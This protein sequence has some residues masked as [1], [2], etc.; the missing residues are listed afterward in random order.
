M[1][2]SAF[3][4]TLSRAAPT[5]EISSSEDMLNTILAGPAGPTTVGSTTSKAGQLAFLPDAPSR[6]ADDPSANRTSAVKKS[7]HDSVEY[8]AEKEIFRA[9]PWWSISGEESRAEVASRYGSTRNA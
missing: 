5:S 8:A 7:Q 6:G 9:P 2:T 3:T 4:F 1:G